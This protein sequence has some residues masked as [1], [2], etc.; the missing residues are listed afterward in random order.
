[1]D[2]D[3]LEKHSSFG[4]CTAKVQV[5]ERLELTCEEEAVYNRLAENG[6]LLEQ[7]RIPFVFSKLK[8]SQAVSS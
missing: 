3:T 4:V 7:E 6:I 8:L 5:K 2:S 1:M